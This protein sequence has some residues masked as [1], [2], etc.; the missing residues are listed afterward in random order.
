MLSG[1]GTLAGKEAPPLLDNITKNPST[2]PLQESTCEYR[3][4]NLTGNSCVPQVS[5]SLKGKGS[6]GELRANLSVEPWHTLDVAWHYS[7]PSKIGRRVTSLCVDGVIDRFVGP[8]FN[9]AGN[10][11]PASR[12]NV[13]MGTGNLKH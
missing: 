4:D 5:K 8:P 7:L 11:D 1:N 9:V 2:T 6:D 10:V 3:K 13:W 12:K